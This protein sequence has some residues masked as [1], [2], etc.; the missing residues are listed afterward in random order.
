M[1]S[2][3]AE[4]TAA[5]PENTLVLSLEGNKPDFSLSKPASDAS[6]YKTHSLAARY[7]GGI[8]ESQQPMRHVAP[9]EAQATFLRGLLDTPTDHRQRHPAE[10]IAS[11]ALHVLVVSLVLIVPLWFTQA[12]DFHNLQ[13]T[14]L[15][16]PKP[17]AAP[18]PP[19]ASAVQ[20]AVRRTP[21]LLQSATLTAPSLI[22]RKVEIVK[23]A[24][25]I[26]ST[27]VTGGIPG[28]ETGG[29]LGGILGGT[30]A[31]SLPPP[32]PP[33]PKRTVYRVGGEVKEPK[34]VKSV[35][36]IYPPIA[37]V[38]HAEGLVTINAII[39]EQGDVVEARAVSG[40]GLLMASALQAV[41]QWK[42]EPTYL[43][44]TPVPIRMEV[45][46]YFHLR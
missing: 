35:D 28:G 22:P 15:A 10:W 32:P 14:Y 36:P 29:V 42:Y 24:P 4:R 20:Q 12:I 1:S 34:L 30:Q 44:G 31:G 19:V 11:V 13:L 41:M 21:R 5:N 45:Q 6:R 8:P 23:D 46:V 25:D 7:W 37:R 18:P 43:N 39:N 27:G 2:P 33:A 9:A 40:P 16:M 17:P 3:V 38:A 26:Q